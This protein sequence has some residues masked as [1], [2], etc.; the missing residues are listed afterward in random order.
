MRTRRA[1]DAEAK[2]IYT[3]LARRRRQR[4]IRLECSSDVSQR[5]TGANNGSAEY[6]IFN[7]QICC[8]L[9]TAVAAVL[10]AAEALTLKGCY[11]I[12]SETT[13]YNVGN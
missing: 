7:R 11:L 9:P 10:R 8:L 6:G 4:G 1:T 2:Q 13:A 3:G 5:K 12:P